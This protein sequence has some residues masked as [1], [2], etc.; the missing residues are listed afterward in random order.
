M[1]R[2]PALGEGRE[3]SG[4]AGLVRL[5]GPVAGD[6][7]PGAGT[8]DVDVGTDGACRKRTRAPEADLGDRCLTKRLLSCARVGATQKLPS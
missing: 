3:Q 7:V 5:A 8:P 1:T 6:R 4:V 2:A